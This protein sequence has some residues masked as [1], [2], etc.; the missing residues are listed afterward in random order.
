M[1]ER[2][3]S[4]DLYQHYLDKALEI[5]RSSSIASCQMLVSVVMALMNLDRMQEAYE[6]IISEMALFSSYDDKVDSLKTLAP[7]KWFNL[8]ESKFY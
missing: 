6:M 8:E 1:A 2:N 5:I 4:K 3:N 7:P